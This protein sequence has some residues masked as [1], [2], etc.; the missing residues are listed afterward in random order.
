MLP[1]PPAPHPSI[2][3]LPQLNCETDFVARND[4][5]KSLVSM[6]TQAIMELKSPQILSTPHLSSVD[7]LTTDSILSIKR[8][9]HGERTL[10]DLVAESIGQ[11]SEN[12][13]IS[14]GCIMSAAKGMICSFAYNNISPSGD[15]VAMGTYA[16]LVHLLPSGKEGLPS[17]SLR[18]L[19]GK[20]CQHVIGVCPKA[21]YPGGDVDDSEALVE[22]NFV[23]DESCKVGD[24]LR[25][26]GVEV[27][28]FVR[29]G[30]GE[31]Q[32]G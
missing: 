20:L 18:T 31:T 14:R 13:A 22:Q 11:L 21:V 29:F 25:E 9:D 19:G 32:E 17:D 28:S 30:L 27:T 23:F 4:T 12:I 24:V 3:L 2:S 7:H 5:F 8:E 1:F 16:A 26:G 10:A 6:T 15:P